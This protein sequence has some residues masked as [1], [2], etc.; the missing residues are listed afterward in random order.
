M[1]GLE[2]HAVDGHRHVP[3]MVQLAVFPQWGVL[4]LG[5]VEPEVLLGPGCQILAGLPQVLAVG[6]HLDVGVMA[7]GTLALGPPAL[8][9]LGTHLT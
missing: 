4:R 9:V 3:T 8:V 2:A 1:P 5:P 6:V 7:L